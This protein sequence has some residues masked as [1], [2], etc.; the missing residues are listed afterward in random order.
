M[1]IQD[2]A[3]RRIQNWWRDLLPPLLEAE[4]EEVLRPPDFAIGEGGVVL[5]RMD[6]WGGELRTNKAACCA[7]T[8]V[9]AHHCILIA[10]S[11]TDRDSSIGHGVT[12][13]EAVRGRSCR[14]TERRQ[15]C[16]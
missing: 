8:G 13:G 16:R 10:C 2:E 1:S 14:G 11:Y 5:N 7:V 3:A 9:F 4:G 12:C 15:Q 6:D